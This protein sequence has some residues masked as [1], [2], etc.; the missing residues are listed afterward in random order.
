[1]GRIPDAYRLR[2]RN[3]ASHG[4]ITLGAMS[5]Q[6]LQECT[7]WPEHRA[8]PAKW[9]E[10]WRSRS[11]P[12]L[13]QRRLNGCKVAENALGGGDPPFRLPITEGIGYVH[14]HEPRH[15][16]FLRNSKEIIRSRLRPQNS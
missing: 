1:M 12:L 4:V 3:L 8:G 10:M 2:R 11:E 15:C 13:N 7:G 14:G 9:M 6:S 16:V 5:S